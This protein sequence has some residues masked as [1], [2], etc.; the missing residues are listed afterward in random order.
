MSGIE[1]GVDDARVPGHC[2]DRRSSNSV[3]PDSGR[4]GGARR[5]CGP[6]TKPPCARR[7]L[8]RRKAPARI[9][10][11]RAIPG[12]PNGR[13]SARF[14]ATSHAPYRGTFAPG[15]DLVTDKIPITRVPGDAGDVGNFPVRDD[16]GGDP[17]KSA[18]SKDKPLRPRRAPRSK[19]RGGPMRF[20]E[21]QK[22]LLGNPLK[23]KIELHSG[24]R[25]PL[26]NIRLT[27]AEHFL[28]RE[29]P[30]FPPMGRV[31][32]WQKWRHADVTRSYRLRTSRPRALLRVK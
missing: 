9:N 15:M 19:V 12:E 27:H 1:A 4:D 10:G 23:P 7:R 5:S 6:S 31:I 30:V 24:G 18:T 8:T 32:W 20:A 16:G 13:I 22:R 11:R 28:Y 17:A 14:H 29:K 26:L 2:D 3:V 21:P 25:V